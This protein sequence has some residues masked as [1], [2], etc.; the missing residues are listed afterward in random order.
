MR[1]PTAPKDKKKSKIRDVNDKLRTVT[2]QEFAATADNSHTLVTIKNEKGQTFLTMK[3]GDTLVIYDGV[4][5]IAC[6]AE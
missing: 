5:R 6:K 4:E 1:A 3:V 2:V